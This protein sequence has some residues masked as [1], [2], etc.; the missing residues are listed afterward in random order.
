[1]NVIRVTDADRVRTITFTRPGQANAFDHAL[2][3]A[4]AG[5]LA[6]AAT[7]DGVGAVV[8]T[9]EGRSFCAGTDLVEMAAMVAGDGRRR[10]VV[11]R[12]HGRRRRTTGSRR[13]STGSRTSP[14]RCWPRSTVPASD[15]G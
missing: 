4:V 1:M 15:W 2:Y 8:L 12:R 13:S 10:I 11:G 7:D 14:S 6:D 9:G 5:A 3:L